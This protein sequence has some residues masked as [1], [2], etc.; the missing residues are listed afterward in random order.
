MT[1]YQDF[2]VHI[3]ELSDILNAISILKWDARTQMPPVARRRVAINWQR[4]RA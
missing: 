4:S 3:A 1:A 2:L